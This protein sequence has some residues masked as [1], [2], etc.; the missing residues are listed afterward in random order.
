MRG[1]RQLLVELPFSSC[2]DLCYNE[3]RRDLVRLILLLIFLV[4]MGV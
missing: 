4:L 2:F 3:I 1:P